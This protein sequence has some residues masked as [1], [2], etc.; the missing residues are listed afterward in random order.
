MADDPWVV[1]S[2][3]VPYLL[4]GSTDLL[5]SAA[6]EDVFSVNLG[7]SAVVLERQG[8]ANTWTRRTTG[9]KMANSVVIEAFSKTVPLFSSVGTLVDWGVPFQGGN[10]VG[11]RCFFGYGPGA[12]LTIPMQVNEWLRA[13]FTAE[14]DGPMAH[15]YVCTTGKQTET[16]ATVGATELTLPAVAAAEKVIAAAFVT[17]FT[18]TDATLKIQ[19]DD[20]WPMT[21]AADIITFTQFTAAGSAHG[22]T[23]V[24]ADTE[25]KYRF[26]LSTSGGITS[27]TFVVFVGIVPA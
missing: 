16:A 23:A 15:G 4:I 10:A 5:D 27:I 6:D 22:E 8:L 2:G 13:N 18:G 12:A 9:A 21:T 14:T 11:D 3:D 20:V 7:K 25:T 1:R 24:G 17:A 19:R 26:D